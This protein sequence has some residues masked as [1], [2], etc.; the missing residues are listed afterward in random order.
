MVSSFLLN[1]LLQRNRNSQFERFR[2]N[3]LPATLRCRFTGLLLLSHEQYHTLFRSRNNSRMLERMASGQE[4]AQPFQSPETFARNQLSASPPA[5]I[6]MV[7]ACATFRREN[8]FTEFT[9]SRT[10][11]CSGIDTATFV[12]TDDSLRLVDERRVFQH[13]NNPIQH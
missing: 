12:F 4:I 8:R 9:G 1:E 11:S 13:P 2:K 6:G 7:L 3:N 5:A 10:A